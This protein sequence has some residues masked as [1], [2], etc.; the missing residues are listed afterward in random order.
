MKNVL[1]FLF[2]L[3]GLFACNKSDHELNQTYSYSDIS[4]ETRN[5]DSTTINNFISFL[6]YNLD[7]CTLCSSMVF[8]ESI[9]HNFQNPN[10]PEK[11]LIVNKVGFDI[12]NE[13]N[14]AFIG[15]INENGG[16]YNPFF[17]ETQK[18]N[19]DLYKI[20]FFSNKMDE[21]IVIELIPSVEEIVVTNYVEEEEIGGISSSL[22][23]NFVLNCIADAYTNH[24]W[25]SVWVLVQSAFIP[26][27]AAAIALA[28]LHDCIMNSIL[29]GIWIP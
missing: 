20:T 11:V 10:G 7:S 14:L 25:V 27:T 18:V 16:M 19:A 29:I 24:G 5:I 22:C 4:L 2:I 21:L 9:V 12:N 8:D 3:I 1:Y 15:V 17:I 13:I 26:E 28:C 23:A 6:H